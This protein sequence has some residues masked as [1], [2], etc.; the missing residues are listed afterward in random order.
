MSISISQSSVGKCKR[1]GMT[2]ENIPKLRAHSAKKMQ[3]NG[4]LKKRGATV[5]HIQQNIVF[6]NILI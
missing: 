2:H 1:K 4:N 3:S 6:I 5:S